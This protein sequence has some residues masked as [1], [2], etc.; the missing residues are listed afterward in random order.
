MNGSGTQQDNGQDLP[1]PK[2][3][4]GLGAKEAEQLMGKRGPFF[5]IAL[6]VLRWLQSTGIYLMEGN[7]SLKTTL[8]TWHNRTN[9]TTTQKEQW[10]TLRE[11]QVWRAQIP[12]PRQ[13][14]GSFGQCFKEH[15]WVTQPCQLVTFYCRTRFHLLPLRSKKTHLQGR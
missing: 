4:T 7:P 13:A 11:G 15:S 2:E 3:P 14:K 8:D 10:L 12:F 1:S 9:R 5:Y 6:T